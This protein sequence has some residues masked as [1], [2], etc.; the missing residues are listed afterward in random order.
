MS[1]PTVLVIEDDTAIRRGLVDALQY[2]GYA[3]LEAADGRS[4]AALAIEATIDLVLLDVMLPGRDGFSILD[5]L[6]RARPTLPVIMVTA[7]GGEEDRVR[8]L[9]SGADDYV[10]KPFSAR[11]LLARVEAVLRRSPERPSDV[12]SL[13]LGNTIVRLDRGEIVEGGAARATLSQRECGILRYLA[14]NA[15]RAIARDEL[16]HRVWGID[17]RGVETRTVDMHVARLRDKLAVS[18]G[19]EDEFIQTVRG[20]GYMLASAVEVVPP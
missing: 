8:G 12:R 20:K 10:I 19:D 2:A 14:A 15:G 4:G 9:V 16:L 3:V 18:A 6:R 5:D 13:R 17:P 7:R 11:E 1:H